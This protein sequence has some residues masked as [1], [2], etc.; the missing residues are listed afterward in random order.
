MFLNKKDSLVSLLFHF[1]MSSCQSLAKRYVRETGNTVPDA[2]ASEEAKQLWLLTQ[3]WGCAPPGSQPGTFIAA[4]V[5]IGSNVTGAE[6]VNNKAAP[7]P[8]GDNIRSTLAT[9]PPALNVLKEEGFL[10][11]VNQRGFQCINR[12][13]GN[14]YGLNYNTG[15]ANAPGPSITPPD[16]QCWGACFNA[17]S[18]SEMCFECINTVLDQNPS[19]CPEINVKDPGDETLIRDAVSC[20]ECVGSQ[21]AFIQSTAPGAQ[22]GDPD[23]PAILNQVWKCITSTLNP[24]L[25]AL[26]IMLIVIAAVIV[27]AV[28]VTLGLYYGYFHP[29]M[30]RSEARRSNL[31]SVGLNP[32]NF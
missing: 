32:D 16:S 26:D 28:A 10:H 14:F 17:T 31:E 2:T 3:E 20:H 11:W 12:I 21:S 19:L 30:L 1:I 18:D 8:S 27:V 7:A 9:R 15:L 24:G 6:G 4:D 29:R 13:V 5:C 25:T 22:P 23:N